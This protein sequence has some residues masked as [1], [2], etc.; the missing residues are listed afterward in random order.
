MQPIGI[1]GGTFDPIHLGHLVAASE[2]AHR[3][4]LDRVVFTPTGDSWHK[5]SDGR[6]PGE[7]RYLMAVGATAS[8]PRFDVSRVDIDREIGRAH[9]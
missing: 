4:D 2:V 5:E 3:F 8:D 1:F 9:V 6:A 7:M